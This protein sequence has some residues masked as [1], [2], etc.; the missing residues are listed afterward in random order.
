MKPITETERLAYEMLWVCE[1]IF[2]I[3]IWK[4][5]YRNACNMNWHIVHEMQYTK[6][7][8][9]FIFDETEKDII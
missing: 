8:V 6:W 9:Q 3:Q 2:D 5:L 1:V 7:T 4:S